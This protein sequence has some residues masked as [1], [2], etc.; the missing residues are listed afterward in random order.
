MK[1]LPKRASDNGG[2]FG[3]PE[4]FVSLLQSALPPPE[5]WG[6]DGVPPTE[7]RA[8]CTLYVGH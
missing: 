6:F 7:R 1:K 3:C 8:L 4:S 5:G 2:C